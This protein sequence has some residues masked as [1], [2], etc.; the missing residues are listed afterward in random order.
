MS[1]RQQICTPGLHCGCEIITSLG[2]DLPPAVT[3]APLSVTF[4]HCTILCIYFFLGC[5][6]EIGV[7]WGGVV[8]LRTMLLL[9]HLIPLCLLNEGQL[10]SGRQTEGEIREGRANGPMLRE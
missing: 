6:P 8:L 2:P 5:A 9:M 3:Q 10:A 4:P 1:V 7:C